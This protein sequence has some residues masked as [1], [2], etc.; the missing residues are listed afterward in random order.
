MRNTQSKVIGCFTALL[1]SFCTQAQVSTDPWANLNDTLQKRMSEWKIPG[2]AIA[3]VQGDSTLFENVYGYADMSKQ[4]KVTKNTLFA[5]GS[6]TKFFTTTGLSVLA[7]E[8]KLDFNAPVI[9]Y[10]PELKLSDSLLRKEI[11]VKDILCHRTGLESGDYIWYGADYSRQEVLDRLVHL[12]TRAH[13]RDAFIYNNSM[14]TLAGAI[15]ERQA[16][17]PYETFIRS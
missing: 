16:N 3:V 1:L 12:K 2:M 13:V 15:L 8:N 10:Y 14:Y 7:D 17:T 11:L 4:L 6:C 9:D 5:I